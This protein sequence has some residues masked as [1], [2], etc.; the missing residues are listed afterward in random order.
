MKNKKFSKKLTFNKETVANLT[1]G[2]M[3]DVK[4]GYETTDCTYTCPTEYWPICQTQDCTGPDTWCWSL[5]YG[6]TLCMGTFC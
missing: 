3:K 2:F 4:G 6:E 5:D 1:T